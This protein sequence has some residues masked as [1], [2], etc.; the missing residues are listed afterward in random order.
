MIPPSLD[1]R[2]GRGLSN[3]YF[4]SGFDMNNIHRKEYK[5]CKRQIRFSVKS[6][7]GHIWD[8]IKGDKGLI[9]PQVWMRRRG[10]LQMH[11]SPSKCRPMI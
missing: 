7:N 10:S 2:N 11:V 3:E 8:F 9:T 4:H 1:L 5:G 6:F